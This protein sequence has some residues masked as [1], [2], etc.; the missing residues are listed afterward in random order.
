VI[1]SDGPRL[2]V[3]SSLQ[4]WLSEF[5][6]YRRDEGQG[7]QAGRSLDGL[8]ALSGYERVASPRAPREATQPCC[9]APQRTRAVS[10]IPPEESGRLAHITAY[11][12]RI[13]PAMNNHRPHAC[14]ENATP[15]ENLR[16]PVQQAG[17]APQARSLMGLVG[18]FS[19]AERSCPA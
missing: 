8:N 3:F 13:P 11:L 12:G 2:F 9:L 10:S 15:R 6:I 16:V 5:R 4:N 18:Q 14:E 1:E 19:A 17:T 7:R